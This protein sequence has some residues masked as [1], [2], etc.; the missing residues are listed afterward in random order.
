MALGK[1]NDNFSESV[2]CS[3]FHIFRVSYEILMDRTDFY[4]YL[5]LVVGDDEN[6]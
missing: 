4:T 1:M 5:K 2:E 6:T 3:F